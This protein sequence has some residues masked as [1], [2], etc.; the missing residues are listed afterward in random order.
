M[1]ANN[2]SSLLKNIVKVGISN[3][4]TIVSGVFVGFLVPKL[5][6]LTNY[7]LYKTFTLYLGYIGL[8]SLG[9]CD[10]INL[11]YAG[12][13]YNEIDKNKFRWFS[14]I[15]IFTQFVFA[16]IL[17]CLSFILFKINL[18][19]S[20]IFCFVAI[21]LLASNIIGYFQQISQ[22]TFRFKELSLRNIIRSV[23]TIIS[24][25]IFYLLYRF[26]FISELKYFVYL[27]IYTI[28]QFLLLVW[29]IYTY[30]DIVLGHSPLDS[31]SKKEIFGIYFKGFPLLLANLVGGYILNFDRQVVN[32]FFDTNVYA[33]YAFAYNLL[34][35]VTTAISSVSTVVYPSMKKASEIELKNKY[36]SISAY[37][38]IFVSF[39]LVGF[40][41]LSVIV[42][43]FLPQYVDSLPIFAIIFPGLIFTSSITLIT[44]NIYKAINWSFRYFVVSV[45]VL[46]FSIAANFIVYSLFK[47]TYA[48]SYASII[49]I[50]I[51]YLVVEIMLFTRWRTI[52]IK[53]MV[54]SIALMITFYLDYLFVKSFKISIFIYLTIF[55]VLTLFFY[56]KEIKTFSTLKKI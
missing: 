16:L 51:W 35:L 33:V 47:T 11:I 27:I 55:F 32:L 8:F 9:F 17:I 49:T 10:G 30:R 40:F 54:Y 42:K 52:S 12:K 23:L 37:L 39:C 19:Y 2:K 46:A 20:I 7:G 48:I 18:N 50:L 14:R 43:Y 36:P 28:I 53:N 34:S 21:N 1:M 44:F 15:Y 3:I 5:M 41:P 6:G 56:E 24:I 4:F 38:L 26:N 31:I 45:A 22:I 25:V 29:Y 13:Q